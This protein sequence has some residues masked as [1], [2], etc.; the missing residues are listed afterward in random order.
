MPSL[1]N[2]ALLL[3]VLSGWGAQP[4]RAFFGIGD[5]AFVTVVANPADD[6]H[7][8]AELANLARQIAALEATVARVE[9]LRVYAGDPRAAAAG[10][11]SLQPILQSV[12]G[13]NADGATAGDLRV[14]WEGGTS[15]QHDTATLALL[16]GTGAGGTMQVFGQTQSRDLSRYAGLAAEQDLTGQARGQIDQEQAARAAI[17]RA[18]IQAWSDY[19]AAQTESQKQ[20]GLTKIQQLQAQSEVLAARRRALLDDLALADRQA[21]MRAQVRIRADDESALAESAG[22]AASAGTRIQAADAQRWATLGK[23]ANPAPAP[24]YS[25]LK[26]WTT[27]DTEGGGP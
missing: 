18:L 5:A 21:G 15:G 3:A 19:Q 17:A 2:R 16:Q 22:L 10:A 24:D 1:R 6:A 26:I 4:A 13:L 23:S 7:W 25:A 27:A 9:S 12:A 14:A 20:A 11:G 8:T